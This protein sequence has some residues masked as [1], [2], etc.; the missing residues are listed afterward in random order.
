MGFQGGDERGGKLQSLAGVG[1][2]ASAELDDA[3][4]T[5]WESRCRRR[6][7]LQDTAAIAAQQPRARRNLG[8]SAADPD[9]DRIG[10]AADIKQPPARA[11]VAETRAVAALEIGLIDA[12][13]GGF[14][15]GQ[16]A[17][18]HSS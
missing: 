14:G 8:R 18:C 5:R 4:V 10:C 3:P 11:G 7:Q 13:S 15:V 6:Q 1:F 9:V 12:A 16:G 17:R 2:T